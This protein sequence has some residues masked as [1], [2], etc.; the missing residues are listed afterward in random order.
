MSYNASASSLGHLRH[1]R[2]DNFLN[3]YLLNNIINTITE[4]QNLAEKT[5]FE[6]F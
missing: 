4:C 2:F 5:F 3:K 6:H 1:I